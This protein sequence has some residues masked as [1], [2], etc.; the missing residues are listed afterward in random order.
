MSTCKFTFIRGIGQISYA[1]FIEKSV[2]SCF[3]AKDEGTL[4]IN[5]AFSKSSLV[6]QVFF[7]ITPYKQRVN[8]MLLSFLES[9]DVAIP[10]GIV[11]KSFA[12][13]EVV[14]PLPLVN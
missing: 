6:L 10:V 1:I 5:F 12:M 2:K 13:R 4:S 9:S 11:F 8:A 3:V 7:V 14:K